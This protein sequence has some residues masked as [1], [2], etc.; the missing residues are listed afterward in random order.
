MDSMVLIMFGSVIAT[1]TGL[2]FM[3]LRKIRKHLERTTP[4]AESKRASAAMVGESVR[5]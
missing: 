5:T 1:I 3:E 2:N 4:V